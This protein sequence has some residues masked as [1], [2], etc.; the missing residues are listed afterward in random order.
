MV[1]VAILDFTK[2]FD[3][4][5]HR[6]LLHYYGINGNIA[7]WIKSFLTGRTQQVV[8]NGTSS[9][10]VASTSGVPQGTVLGPFMCLA[11]INNLPSKLI[12]SSRLFA[13]DCLL[14]TPV[15]SAQDRSVLQD[16]LNDWK[17]GKTFGS[18]N[19][20]PA[21]VLLWQL[22]QEKSPPPATPFVANN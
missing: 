14:Y 5:P 13:D 15:K 6:R 11:Y 10:S 2:A 8:V 18:C 7:K 22:L 3:K 4:I 19:S 1:D 17:N 12:S 20:T 16:D 21:S 9:S